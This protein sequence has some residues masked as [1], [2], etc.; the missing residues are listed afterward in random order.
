MIQNVPNN[1]DLWQDIPMINLIFIKFNKFLYSVV[2][3]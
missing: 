3:I 1:L 2:E